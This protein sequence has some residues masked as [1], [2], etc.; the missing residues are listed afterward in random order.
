MNRK[1]DD[2]DV[3]KH[4][5]FVLTA[6]AIGVVC[7]AAAAAVT[8]FALEWES[9]KSMTL[10]GLLAGFGLISLIVAGVKISDRRKQ[11]RAEPK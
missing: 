6:V 1:P 5:V 8:P 3:R 2:G 10:P 9:R 4:R 7:I 11:R